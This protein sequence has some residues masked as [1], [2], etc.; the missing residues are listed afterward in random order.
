MIPELVD[1]LFP[2][3]I[4]RPYVAMIQHRGGLTRRKAEYFVRLW[5]YLFLKQQEEL[6]GQLPTNLE[7]LHAPNGLISCTHRE[8]A[9]LFYGDQ[10][11]G[12]DRSAGMMIDR[13]V[14]LGLLEKQYDGNSLCLQ[15]RSLPE[16]ELPKPE[17]PIELF[18]DAF[19]PRTD[20]I[21]I[22]N[23]Y[24]R[25]YAPM[26]RD[27][28]A[29]SKVAKVL[30]IWSQQYSIG[31]RVLRRSDNEGVVA[32]SVLFPVASE[33]DAYFFQQP[34]R[35]FY[36][37]TDNPVDPFV[38]APPGDRTCLSIYIRAWVIDQPHLTVETLCHLLEDTQQTLRVVR[39]DY[40]EICDLY[41]LIVHP[42]YEKLRHV[43]GFE[44]ICEDNQRSFAW[45]HCAIDR[46]LETDM[47]QALSNLR[48]GD[49][50]H[51]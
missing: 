8:A 28:A 12:S 18:A 35:S 37:T 41:T 36:L 31:M 38:M 45:V 29:M 1:R 34:S 4:Q 50:S 2:I 15:I 5:A 42:I 46:F 11:R 44:R 43:L 6:S 32:A 23:L 3:E 40:P 33:S 27:G 9:E 39:N 51:S 7:E 24:T 20:A 17:K 16:L 13:L 25:N 10:D 21:S 26:I 47:K 30:R 14:A 19:N 49:A 22:A 48:I